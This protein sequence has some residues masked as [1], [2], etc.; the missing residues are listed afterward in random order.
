MWA[1]LW[2]ADNT[3]AGLQHN[4]YNMKQWRQDMPHG[5][6]CNSH[7]DTAM[8]AVSYSGQDKSTNLDGDNR[9]ILSQHNPYINVCHYTDQRSKHQVIC[10]KA[11]WIM[12]HVHCIRSY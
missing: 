4:D 2:R 1:L 5:S 8:T 11:V 10:Y 12:C 6:E 3:A 9:V 7:S